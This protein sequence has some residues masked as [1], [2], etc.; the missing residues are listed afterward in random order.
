METFYPDLSERVQSTF[1][2][3]ILLVIAMFAATAL[4]DKFDNVPDSVRVAVF[5]G[6][7]IAYEPLLMTFGCTLGNYMKGI[8]VRK[9]A[10]TTKKINILQALVRYPIKL[11]LG[12]ISFLTINSDSKRRAIHDLAA[13]TVM[14]KA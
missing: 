13:G 6:L 5:V 8:R 1:I 3:M 2:D 14:V 11:F 9:A 7:W 4:L 12:W 10:D